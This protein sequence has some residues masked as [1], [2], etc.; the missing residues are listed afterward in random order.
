M[1]GAAFKEINTYRMPSKHTFSFNL[2]LE[3]TPR[4]EGVTHGLLV[5]SRLFSEIEEKRLEKMVV[6]PWVNGWLH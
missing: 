5:D 4:S 1:C 2:D 6:A 3:A